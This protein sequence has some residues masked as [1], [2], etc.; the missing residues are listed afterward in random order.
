MGFQ[1]FFVSDVMYTEFSTAENKR[2]LILLSTDSIIS[3][4]FSLTIT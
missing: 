1:I 3:P 2:V 4:E